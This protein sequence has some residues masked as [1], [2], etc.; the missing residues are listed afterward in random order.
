MEELVT[1]LSRL[2]RRVLKELGYVCHT[3]HTHKFIPS[4]LNVLDAPELM[5]V[6]WNLTNDSLRTSVRSYLRCGQEIWSSPS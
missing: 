2:E 3:E 1:D 6:A 5:Q 4:Y